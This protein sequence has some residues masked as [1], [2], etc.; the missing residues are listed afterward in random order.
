MLPANRT[1]PSAH[2]VNRAGGLPYTIS[3]TLRIARRNRCRS[4]A[5]LLPPDTLKVTDTVG[6]P[7]IALARIDTDLGGSSAPNLSNVDRVRLS[8]SSI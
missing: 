1:G 8:R 5:H 2:Q 4:R 6:A 7:A 3:L